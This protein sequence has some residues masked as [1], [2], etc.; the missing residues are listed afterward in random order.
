VLGAE[1]R[2]GTLHPLAG[3]MMV[4]QQV[5]MK[6]AALLLDLPAQSMTAPTTMLTKELIESFVNQEK[7]SR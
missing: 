6:I 7:R 3:F 5:E 4:S 2:R 1:E